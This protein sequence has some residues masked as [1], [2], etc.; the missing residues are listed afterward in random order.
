MTASPVDPFSAATAL[1]AAAAEHGFDWD[2]PQGLWDKLAEEIAELREA[3]EPAHRQEELG[4]LLF[5]I[6]NIARHLGLDPA[7]ALDAANTKFRRRY[8]HVAAHLDELPPL[9]DPQRLIAMEQLWQA[10]KAIER[11]GVPTLETARLTL[12]P[13]NHGD[14]AMILALLNTPGFLNQIG[15]RGVRTLAD[16]R[17]YIDEGPLAD[18]RQHRHGLLAVIA[19]SSGAAVGLCGLLRRESL[20][21]A[22]LGYAL[23]PDAVGQGLAC[24]AG[25]AVLDDAASRLALAEVLAIVKP[26]NDASLR[27]LQRLGFARRGD[28]QLA[29]G[30]P[31]LHLLATSLR[32]AG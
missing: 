31:A 4:D 20:P 9:G 26:G 21:T 22:D 13:L 32:R 3:A 5:M 6:A 1:Q 16:A 18:Y 24:E 10:A 29:P 23:L 27:V 14:A 19:R 2:E 17:R 30:E 8:G 12:R 28:V 11:I 15:D 25:A 7:R